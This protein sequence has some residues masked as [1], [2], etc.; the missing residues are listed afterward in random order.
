MRHPYRAAPDRAFW[1]RA[2]AR[3][4][5]PADVTRG[6]APLLRRADRVASA[7]SCFAA[8]IVPQLEAA[9]FR[10]VRTEQPHPAL[11]ATHVEAL[12]YHKFSAA[13]GNIYT[14]RHLLQLLQR[15][16]AAFA[17]S[18]IAG[19]RRTQWSMHSD[20]AWLFRPRPTANSTC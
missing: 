1:E 19:T 15:A 4:Y 12:S 10:Y 13:Y 6:G 17:H 3:D 8:N 2:V 14:A 20:P 11:A 5:T 9:G 16:L 7:G 18:R